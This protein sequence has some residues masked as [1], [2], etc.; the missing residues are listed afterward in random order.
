LHLRSKNKL[1]KEKVK[2]KN[3]NIL[4]KFCK[5]FIFNYLEIKKN[6]EKA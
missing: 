3:E 1:K 5:C 4:K 2:A 6:K